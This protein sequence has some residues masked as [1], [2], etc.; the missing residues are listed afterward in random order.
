MPLFI[1]PAKAKGVTPVVLNE[2]K[3]HSMIDLGRVF[4]LR[5]WGGWIY[6]S[7]E[8]AK[9]ATAVFVPQGT[10]ED[11]EEQLPEQRQ[12]TEEEKVEAQKIAKIAL[13]TSKDSE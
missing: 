2:M 12:L 1:D 7:F 9:V 8:G 10:I 13:K 11:G 6:W 5:V 3:L 4:I